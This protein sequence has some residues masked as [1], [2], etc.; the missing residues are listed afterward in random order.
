MV[1]RREG[2]Q[3]IQIFYEMDEKLPSKSEADSCSMDEMCDEK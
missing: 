1:T 2:V 3:L